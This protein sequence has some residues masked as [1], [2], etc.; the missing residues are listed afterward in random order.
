[1][2]SMYFLIPMSLLVLLAAT[3][4]LIWAV[5]SGQYDDMEREAERILQDDDLPGEAERQGAGSANDEVR[6]PAA[7]EERDD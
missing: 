3:G 2:E 1:M 7:G 5:N 4:L 6:Q